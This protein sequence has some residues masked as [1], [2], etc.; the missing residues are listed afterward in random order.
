MSIKSARRRK[1]ALSDLIHES[2]VG[3]DYAYNWVVAGLDSLNEAVDDKEEDADALADVDLSEA[4]DGHVDVYTS[5]LTEWLNASNYNIYYLDEAA[6]EGM[7]ENL[8]GAA[9]YKAI[10]EIFYGVR[11]KLMDYLAE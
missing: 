6:K 1:N 7:T 3:E 5:K 2:K 11:D 10:E 9:Q 4:V 8:L